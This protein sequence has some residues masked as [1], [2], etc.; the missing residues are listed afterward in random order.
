MK[1]D[2][3]DP[4]QDGPLTQERLQAKLQALGYEITRYVY[5][6]GTYFAPHSH[7]EDKIDAVLSGQFRITMAGQSV[8]LGPGDSIH[9]PQGIEH[10]AEVV[11]KESVVSLDAVKV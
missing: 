5:P 4:K 3:W 10:S 8:I 2:R 9:V 6:P 11:G 7:S 1:I